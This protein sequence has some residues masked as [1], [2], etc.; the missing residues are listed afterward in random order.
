MQRPPPGFNPASVALAT[1][2]G[3]AVLLLAS[4]RTT[5][6]QQRTARRC[7]VVVLGAGFGGLNAALPLARRRGVELTV[8]DAQGHHLFQPLLYQ[9]ATAALTPGDIAEPV[10]GIIRAARKSRCCKAP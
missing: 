4:R 7:R 10:R 1:L 5:P 2:A 6:Q 8:L 9:V 3:G